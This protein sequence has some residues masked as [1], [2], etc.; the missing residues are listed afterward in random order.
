MILCSCTGKSDRHAQAAFDNGVTDLEGLKRSLGMGSK[1]GCCEPQLIA[2]L[3]AKRWA[4]GMDL[5][6]EPAAM[7]RAS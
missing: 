7:E 2:L 1:C 4:C 5:L 6:P 3:N